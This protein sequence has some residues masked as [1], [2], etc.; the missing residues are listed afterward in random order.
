MLFINIW[1]FLRP[2]KEIRLIK[3]GDFND[4]L[5]Y[6]NLTGDKGKIKEK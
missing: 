4:D 1:L 6:I 5:S 2:H 3:W